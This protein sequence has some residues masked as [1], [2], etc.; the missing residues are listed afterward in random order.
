MGAAERIAVAISNKVVVVER[1]C[2]V[3]YEN[4]T[5]VLFVSHTML[6]CTFEQNRKRK[7]K[8]GPAEI[9]KYTPSNQCHYPAFRGFFCF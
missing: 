2:V 8:N 1:N 6:H 9:E 7:G 3:I 4:R 5:K